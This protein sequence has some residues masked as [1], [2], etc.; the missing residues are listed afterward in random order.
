MT[1]C[2]TGCSQSSGPATSSSDSAGGPSRG[3]IRLVF[4]RGLDLPSDCS[5]PEAI[6]EGRVHLVHPFGRNRPDVLEHTMLDR[7]RPE[8]A[9]E[10]DGI[11]PERTLTGRA[12]NLDRVQ[13]IVEGCRTRYDDPGGRGF[14]SVVVLDNQTRTPAGLLRPRGRIQIDHDEVAPADA[15]HHSGTSPR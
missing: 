12:Q 6:L 4:L 11:L 14:V 10:R 13:P 3:P 2:S 1:Q 7:D 5:Q 8:L 9:A 15:H